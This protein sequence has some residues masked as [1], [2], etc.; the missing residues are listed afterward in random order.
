[1]NIRVERPI[2]TLDVPEE[3]PNTSIVLG[4]NS[5]AL[6]RI[7]SS[8]EGR[9]WW[10]VPDSGSHGLIPVPMSWPDVLHTLGPV[11]EVY[12]PASDVVAAAEDVAA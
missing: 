6:Q 10:Q 1:M 8:W 7:D 2:Y 12:R 5:R 11:V 4:K 9:N 3:P